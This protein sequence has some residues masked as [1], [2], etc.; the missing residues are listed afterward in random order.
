MT[1][2][3]RFMHLA[4]A[5]L[6]DAIPGDKVPI[7]QAIQAIIANPPICGY[8]TSFSPSRTVADSA[9]LHTSP[10]KVLSPF[11]LHLLAMPK[12]D[13]LAPEILE[14][15]S[16]GTDTEDVLELVKSCLAELGRE[17]LDLYRAIWGSKGLDKLR[18]Q[19]NLALWCQVSWRTPVRPLPYAE[20]AAARTWI[21]SERL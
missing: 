9:V 19:L 16:D 20:M 11:T 14:V 6:N 13:E 7:V 12:P 18:L 5:N 1:E 10:L 3:K 2:G 4:M 17:R 21:S 8:H 15:Y